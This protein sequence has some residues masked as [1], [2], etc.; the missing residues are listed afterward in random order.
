MKKLVLL[1]IVAMVMVLGISTAT[2]AEEKSTTC[3]EFIVGVGWEFTNWNA[4]SKA[5][6]EI[7]M[8]ADKTMQGTTVEGFAD[9]V[10]IKLQ[11]D[12]Y[13]TGKVIDSDECIT[14]SVWTLYKTSNKEG[15]KVLLAKEYYTMKK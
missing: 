5:D 2:F 11:S 7:L 4:L 14:T 6:R 9:Q 12:Y 15:N 3:R 8:T 10:T 1:I 13:V